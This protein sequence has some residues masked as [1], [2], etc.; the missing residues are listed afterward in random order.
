M[1]IIIFQVK[2]KELLDELYIFISSKQEFLI[3]HCQNYNVSINR[4]MYYEY[5]CML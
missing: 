1:I 4:G 3:R 2:S 5:A